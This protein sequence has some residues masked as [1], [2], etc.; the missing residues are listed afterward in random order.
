M[1]Q[2]TLCMSGTSVGS[3]G[4]HWYKV[5]FFFYTTYHYLRFTI[6][7]LATDQHNLR[8]V[9]EFQDRIC[10]TFKVLK[11]QISLWGL[12]DPIVDRGLK[13]IN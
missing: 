10:Y 5:L 12:L 6:F 13:S 3:N 4:P 2:I 9:K 8:K 11:E 1:L 7:Q